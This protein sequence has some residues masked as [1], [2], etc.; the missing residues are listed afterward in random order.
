MARK[1]LELAI[2]LGGDLE[3]DDDGNLYWEL[4]CQAGNENRMPTHGDAVLLK[5]FY[6]CGLPIGLTESEQERMSLLQKL[7]R[8]LGSLSFLETPK[9]FVATMPH[10]GVNYCCC[11]FPG[12]LALEDKDKGRSGFLGLFGGLKNLKELVG[13]V[14]AFTRETRLA[15]G[16]AEME[17]IVEQWP[18]LERIKLEPPGH[19]KFR[20]HEG[21]R[22]RSDD[23]CLHWLQSQRPKLKVRCR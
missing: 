11:S 6:S 3:G 13:S 15:L 22:T 9:T 12:M 10:R 17:W 7:Y 2:N 5:T 18:K 8:Q 4:G 1:F 20:K 23:G 21:C 16:L 19:P 14:S